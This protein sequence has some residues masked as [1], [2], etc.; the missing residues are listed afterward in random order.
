MKMKFKII[1]WIIIFTFS[2]IIRG[3]LFAQQRANNSHVNIRTSF[4]YGDRISN[5][6]LNKND[7]IMISKYGT[8][9]SFSLCYRIHSTPGVEI[10]VAYSIFQDEVKWRRSWEDYLESGEDINFG[11]RKKRTIAI[12]ILIHYYLFNKNHFIEPYIGAGVGI[13]KG[14]LDEKQDKL[15]G[16]LS[17]RPEDRYWT[18]SN[19]E[20]STI[21]YNGNAILMKLGFKKSIKTYPVGIFMEI[22]RVYF[23]INSRS[24]NNSSPFEFMNYYALAAGIFFKF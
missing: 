5:V 4:L 19:N 16:N 3:N 10:G 13:F 24:E 2:V 8:G 18:T 23:I 14:F 17:L 6:D 9:G 15:Y 12:E 7:E 1:P 11:Q 22:E 20:N 21:N